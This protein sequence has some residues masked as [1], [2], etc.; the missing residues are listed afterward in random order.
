MKY[1]HEDNGG[2][3]GERSPFSLEGA[4][5]SSRASHLSRK[6]TGRAS[7]ATCQSLQERTESHKPPERI[8]L[9]IADGRYESW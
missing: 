5:G 4:G 2:S 8:L 3:G 9:Q 1:R 7:M 6:V